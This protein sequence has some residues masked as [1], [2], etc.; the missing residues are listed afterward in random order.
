MKKILKKIFPPKF[1]NYWDKN[2]N[3]KNYDETLKFITENFINSKSYKFVSN[4]WHLL[5]IN[6]FKSLKNNGLDKYG[7]EISTHYFTFLDYHD[8]HIKNLYYN[9]DNQKRID[10]NVNIFK[11]QNNL[12]YKTSITYNMLCLLLFENLKLSKNFIT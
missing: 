11:K 5:N 9:F 2:K 4:Q 3:S 7:S 12:N 8:E 10:I 1:K 6:D